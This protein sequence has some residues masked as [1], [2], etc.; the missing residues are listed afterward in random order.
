MKCSKFRKIAVPL[1]ME[2]GG[3]DELAL[4]LSMRSPKL[5]GHMDS[6]EVCRSYLLSCR[7]GLGRLGQIE[8]DQPG[9]REWEKMLDAVHGAAGQRSPL[10]RV[11]WDDLHSVSWARVGAVAAAA[12]LLFITSIAYFRPQSAVKEYLPAPRAA[13]VQP[14][15]EVSLAFLEEMELEDRECSDI[16]SEID[17]LMDEIETACAQVDMGTGEISLE[18]GISDDILT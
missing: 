7:A 8:I 15:G 11:V 17:G 10:Y 16:I 2:T 5:R 13:S 18:Y 12:L 4:A 14:A 3:D 1:L 6:C 9:G